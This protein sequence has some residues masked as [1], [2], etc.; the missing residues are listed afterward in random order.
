MTILIFK[1]FLKHLVYREM[2]SNR[3]DAEGNTILASAST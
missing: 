1:G 3:E 2:E